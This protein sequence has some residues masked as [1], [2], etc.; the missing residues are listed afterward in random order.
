MVLLKYG[1]GRILVNRA[2]LRINVLR[3]SAD[4]LLAPP[5][6]LEVFIANRQNLKVSNLMTLEGS[7]VTANYVNDIFNNETYYMIDVTGFITSEMANVLNEGNGLLIQAPSTTLS[8]NFSRVIFGDQ[9]S[10]KDRNRLDLYYTYL[11]D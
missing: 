5:S 2:Y 3:E 10:D 6:P 7:T 4:Q 8:T 1:F 9:K 11:R